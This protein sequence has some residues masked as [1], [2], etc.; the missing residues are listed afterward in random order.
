MPQVAALLMGSSL[1]LSK[2]VAQLTE[3]HSTPE[4]GGEVTEL[5]VRNCILDLA[6]RKSFAAR[7]GQSPLLQWWWHKA[8]V[9]ELILFRSHVIFM[10]IK[11]AE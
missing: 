5:A 1:P 8:M 7:N 6:A 11:P 4:Q 9:L 2:L 10:Q 3:L